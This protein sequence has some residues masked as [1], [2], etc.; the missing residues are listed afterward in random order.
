V[1]FSD[2]EDSRQVL[3]L[4]TNLLTDSFR[5][6]LSLL[7]PPQ[8]LAAALV[9]L[10]LQIMNLKPQAP[11]VGVFG[12]RPGYSPAGVQEACDQ[13]WLDLLEKDVDEKAVRGELHLV[14]GAALCVVVC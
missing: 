9:F 7:Y 3:R 6:M 11:S 14:G 10:A 5:C 4:A 2:P 1:W 13:T 12:G 8:Q